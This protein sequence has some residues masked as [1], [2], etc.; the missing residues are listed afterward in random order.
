MK[1]VIAVM[2]SVL[3]VCCM[4]SC[5]AAQEDEPVALEGSEISLIAYGDTIED[6]AFNQAA[7]ECIERFSAEYQIPAKHYIT[8]EDG[9]DAYLDLIQ[10]AAED[11]AKIIVMTGS[12]FETTA[13]EAQKKYQDIKFLLVDGVPHD[14]Q[15]HYEIASN[16]ISV[17]FAEEEAGYLAGYAVVRDGYRKLGFLGGEEL[18]AIKR[19]GYGFVQGAAAAAAELNTRVEMKYAYTG[20]LEASKEIEQQA[21]DWYQAGTEVIFACGGSMGKSVMKTAETMEKKVVGV[22]IDQSVLS[23]TVITSAEKQIDVA[24]EGVLKDYKNDTFVGGNAFN[25]AARNNGISLE[26]EH[27]RFQTFQEEDYETVL[28]KIETGEIELKKDTGVK[29]VNELAG[30]RVK[31]SE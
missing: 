24:V 9:Q 31:I 16:A 10:Q 13:Y 15:D 30:N 21:Q 5:G 19:Y 28:K 14:D 25:Y 8:A 26:L 11:G 6:G 22:D 29:S 3:F 4:A 18:P 1:R 27:A 17:V 7:W 23:E 20:T 2:L 12:H